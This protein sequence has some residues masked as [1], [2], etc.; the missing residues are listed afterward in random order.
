LLAVPTIML[1]VTLAFT[2]LWF[3]PGNA[4]LWAVAKRAPNA[5]KDTAAVAELVRRWVMCD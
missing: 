2:A 3:W 4:A 1:F 5:I